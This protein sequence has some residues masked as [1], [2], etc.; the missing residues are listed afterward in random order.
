M[1]KAK[2][3]EY[4]AVAANNTDVNGVNIAENCPP[5]GMNNMG[6]E[7]MAALKR[8]QTGSDG[9]GVTVGGN[10]VV[11][12]TSTLSTT[13]ISSAD[14][15]AG[16]IDG[17]AIGGSTPAAGSFTTLNTSGAVVFNDAGADVDFRVEG[18]T[19][20]NLIVADAGADKVTL[21]DYEE[22]TWTPSLGGNTTYGGQVGYYVKVGSLVI[23]QGQVGVTTIGTGSTTVISGLP[24]TVTNSNGN[25]TAGSIAY[26]DALN[27]NVIALYAYAQPNNTQVSFMSSNTSGATPTNDPAAIFK[28]GTTVQFTMTYRAA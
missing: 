1:T 12:G 28:N 23:V 2:I 27:V 24:F 6:R 4:D 11:S 9:D 13:S 22:G 18:D 16:T 3:S 7:I 20:A 26:F 15:N 21:D 19:N 8:F 10:L 14:I 5:S 25:R 17:T